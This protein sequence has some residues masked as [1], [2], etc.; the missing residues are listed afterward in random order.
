VKR[1]PILLALVSVLV[2]AACGDAE[3]TAA[4]TE[5][6]APVA[7][8]VVPPAATAAPAKASAR[9][10]GEW[11]IVLSDQEKR[12]VD[13][14]QLALKDPAPTQEDMAKMNL[15]EDEKTMVGLMAAAKAKNPSDPKVAQ[16]KAAADGLGQASVTITADHMTFHAGP[17]TQDSTYTVTAETDS[18]VSIQSADPAKA[19]A[20]AAAAGTP[21]E[22]NMATIT[23]L[24]PDT[25][26]LSDSEDATKKQ[27]FKRK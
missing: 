18:T 8:P 14:L 10:L 1:S 11:S 3:P 20:A 6:A 9:L 27:T 25:I 26:E 22:Q 7:P 15:T 16:M 19:E 4:S 23:F 21:P 12:Q 13:V 5:A 2:L 17:V 24:D